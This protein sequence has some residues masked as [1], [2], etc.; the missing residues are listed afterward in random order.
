MKLERFDVQIKVLPNAL[1]HGAQADRLQGMI[2]GDP[3]INRRIRELA[4]KA[5][6]RPQVTKAATGA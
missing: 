4:D 6:R 2:T 3:E 5:M 1:W